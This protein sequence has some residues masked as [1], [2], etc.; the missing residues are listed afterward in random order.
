[1]VK[2][3]NMICELLV[4]SISCIEKVQYHEPRGFARVSA[5]HVN[6]HLSKDW[7]SFSFYGHSSQSKIWWN[8]VDQ[9]NALEVWHLSYTIASL[10]ATIETIESQT[11]FMCDHE[12]LMI[13][14]CFVQ[15]NHNYGRKS[16]MSYIE[17]KVAKRSAIHNL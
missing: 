14:K 3:V 10:C 1:M 11:I 6:P 17:T 7:I 8:I 16:V 5:A 13:L 15:I 2:H 12:I 9:E 4:S